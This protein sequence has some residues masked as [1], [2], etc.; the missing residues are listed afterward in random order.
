MRSCETDYPRS[1]LCQP[2]SPSGVGLLMRGRTDNGPQF[3]KLTTDAL[4]SPV[5]RVWKG[6]WQ[7]A[8]AQVSQKVALCKRRDM[9]YCDSRHV[10]LD[11]LL[12]GYCDSR[13]V[14]LDALLGGWHEARSC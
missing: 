7:R 13:H 9:G 6:Y 10:T 5:S 2:A 8:A 4:D 12:G 1:E 3:K 11:A 14:T